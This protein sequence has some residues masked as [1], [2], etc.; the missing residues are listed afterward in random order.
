MKKRPLGNYPN[1][2]QANIIV[3]ILIILVV[4]SAFVVVANVVMV[5][6]KGASSDVNIGKFTTR[7]EIKEFS[8]SP[9]GDYVL[10]VN[11]LSGSSKVDSLKF[12]F[13]DD[14]GE[15]QEIIEPDTEVPN[16]FETKEYTYVPGQDISLQG[17]I[18]KVTILPYLGN[19]IGFTSTMNIKKCDVDSDCDDSNIC[20]TNTCNSNICS[21]SPRNC[22]DGKECTEDTCVS[23]GGCS[24]NAIPFNGNSCTH[25]GETNCQVGRC[26][27]GDCYLVDLVDGADCNDGDVCNGMET[28]QDGA[29]ND[30]PDLVCGNCE[31]CNQINGCIPDIVRPECVPPDCTITRASCLEHLNAFCDTDGIYKIDP[32]GVGPQPEIDVFCDMTNDGGGWTLVYHG[33]CTSAVKASWTVGNVVEISND[34]LFNQMRISA[35][36]WD[37]SDI[38]TIEVGKTAR[39]K[40]TFSEYF[41]DTSDYVNFYRESED[42][43]DVQFNN[44]DSML[45]G[46]YWGTILPNFRPNRHIEQRMYLGMLGGTG[47]NYEEWSAGVY[48]YEMYDDT[49]VESG[50]GLTRREFQ[51]IKA[52]V[53]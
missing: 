31:V 12:I 47:I 35:V 23:P 10:K 24:N 2:A 32:D 11:R 16:E 52:Y 4:I 45:V 18:V 6:T 30:P 5:I 46:G 43:Q 7:F 44:P 1:K 14:T 19:E 36:N 28:C 37:Y 38:S 51:E 39:M 50:L 34:I 15:T 27:T 41:Q 22:D 13:E 8:Q 29:C 42:I 49:I 40:N 21:V 48:D 3:I 33:L 53:K 17:D 20:T 9:T 26:S 25:D